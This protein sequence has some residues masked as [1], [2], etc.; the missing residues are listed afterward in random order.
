MTTP[1]IDP[2]LIETAVEDISR[3]LQPFIALIPGESLVAAS[4]PEI[5]TLLKLVETFTGE[6]IGEQIVLALV[7]GLNAGLNKK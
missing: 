7:Q 2:A 1:A 4:L 3:A 5:E 6:T